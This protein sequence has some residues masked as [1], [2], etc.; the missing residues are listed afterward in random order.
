MASTEKQKTKKGDRPQ[1]CYQAK[2]K[3]V[4]LLV[5]KK[6]KSR[7]LTNKKKKIWCLSRVDGWE[8]KKKTEKIDEIKK[9]TEKNNFG[10]SA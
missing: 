10:A 8:N 7:K 1:T 3:L 9:R 6:E 5:L 4:H 2:L